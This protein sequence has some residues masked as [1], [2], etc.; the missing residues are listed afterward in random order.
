MHHTGACHS[1]EPGRQ[2]RCTLVPQRKHSPITPHGAAAPGPVPGESPGEVHRA[3]PRAAEDLGDGA[4]AAFVSVGD[5]QLHA[6]QPLGPKELSNS[7]PKA[8]VSAR[9]TPLGGMFSRP[10]R[11]PDLTTSR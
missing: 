5:S 11:E 6:A 7:R 9:L 8:S 2:A 1:G 10:A 3:L 4:L